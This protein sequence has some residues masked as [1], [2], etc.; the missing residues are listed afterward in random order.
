M[1]KLCTNCLAIDDDVQKILHQISL[2]ILGMFPT[3]CYVVIA[4]ALSLLL[5]LKSF[6]INL[7]NGMHT[8]SFKLVDFTGR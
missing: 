2:T 1:F 7:S 8:R 3:S 5:A 6:H 4:E